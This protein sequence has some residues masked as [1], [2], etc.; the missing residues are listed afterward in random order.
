MPAAAHTEKDGSFTNTQ[1][2]LQWHHKAVEPPGDCRSELWFYYHLGRI[3]REKLA[4]SADAIDRPVLDLQW[5]YPTAGEIARTERGGGAARDQRH[6]RRT[7]QL[8]AYTDLKADGSTACGCWI[9]CGV[10]ADGTNQA[11]RRKPGIASRPG[12]LPSGAGR[13]PRTAASSTTVPPPTPRAGP[14]RERKRYVWWDEREGQ[15]DGRRR[16]RLRAG[17][18]PRLRA[19]RR[20]EGPGHDRGQPPV[21]HAG[22]R[23]RLAVRPGRP[24][25]DGPLPTHYEPEESPFPERALRAAVESG[26]P[27]LPAPRQPYNDG[28]DER[29][30]PYVLTTYRLTEHHTAG[31]MSRTLEYLSELQPAMFCEVSPQLAAERG[32]EQRRLGDRAHRRAPRSRR[33]CWSPS[34]L[35]P[36]RVP[37][38]HRPPGGAAL[39]LGL[40]RARRTGG[41]ANDLVAITLDPNVHIQ[42]VKAATCDVRPGGCGRG[43]GRASGRDRVRAP[44]ASR[45]TRDGQPRDGLLH[46]HQRLHRLQGLRG[47][48]QGVERRARGRARVHGAVLRQHRRAGR[49]HLASRRL[50][51]AARRSRATAPTRCAG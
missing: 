33:G 27:A 22:R 23:P 14:G 34:A 2:L 42:E 45:P 28:A 29:R 30:F 17:Q 11:A 5:D 37:G 32:L 1:R 47:G 6:G 9:Y 3:I 49:R 15:V 50:R 51:R 7:A 36:L 20:R 40:A 4:G 44:T 18:A 35:R 26:S 38:Q 12:W 46:R 24:G 39:P 21:H 16:A 31:G 19:A 10:F 25:R 43:H 8:S 48:L 13:G 41:A